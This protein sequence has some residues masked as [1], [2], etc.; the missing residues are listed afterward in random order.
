MWVL[1]RLLNFFFVD[2]AKVRKD[3]LDFTAFTHQLLSIYYYFSS[4]NSVFMLVYHFLSGTT[5]L[6]VIL[7]QR[8]WRVQFASLP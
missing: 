5:L 2:V 8:F 3:I 6:V 7:L 4:L 1:V